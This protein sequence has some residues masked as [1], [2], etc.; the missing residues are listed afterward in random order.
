MKQ[1]GLF[2]IS[3]KIEVIPK[4]YYILRTKRVKFNCSTC[5][6][7]LV[8]ASPAQSIVPTSNYGDSLIMDVAL[9]KFCDLIPIER[10]VQMARRM[11]IDGDL[12]RQSLI[13]ITHHFA[14]F[15][16]VINEKIKISYI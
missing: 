6:G 8:T 13:G 12:P 5:Y 11:G 1:S 15:L 16:K 14:N 3:E 9:S 7:S 10:Y 2:E 4:Q